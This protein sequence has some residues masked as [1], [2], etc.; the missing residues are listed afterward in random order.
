MKQIPRI[1][2]IADIKNK[3]IIVEMGFHLSRLSGRSDCKWKAEILTKDTYHK[4]EDEISARQNIML[5]EADYEIL[6]NLARGYLRAMEVDIT[7]CNMPICVKAENVAI[8]C[9]Y[10]CP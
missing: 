7:A 2:S 8:M 9:I 6:H 10:S 1:I 3:N 4:S 5:Y